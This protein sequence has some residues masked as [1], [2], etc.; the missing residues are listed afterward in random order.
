MRNHRIAAQKSIASEAVKVFGLDLEVDPRDALLAEVHRTAGAIDWLREQI[1]VLDPTEVTD[2]P[3]IPLYRQERKH[4]IDVC[5]AAI[6]AGIEERRVRLAE[7]QGTL[8]ADVIRGILGDLDLTPDQAAR[9]SEVV[10]QRLRAL[11]DVA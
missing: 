1:Q 6:S 3:W 8:L 11:V 4:L 2:S 5:R 7:Q 10:P 9:V